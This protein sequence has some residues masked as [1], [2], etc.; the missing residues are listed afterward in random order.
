MADHH[1]DHVRP[2]G[3]GAADRGVDLLRVQASSLLEE[4]LAAVALLR[5][6][7]AGDALDVADDVNSHRSPFV[8]PELEPGAF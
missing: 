4:R 3:V 2:A 6:H 5:L 1:D 7:D 8:R